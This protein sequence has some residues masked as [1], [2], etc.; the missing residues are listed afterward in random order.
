MPAGFSAVSGSPTEVRAAADAWGVRYARVDTDDPAA[1]L[2]SH[3]ADVFLVDAAGTLRARFPFGTDAPTMTAVIDALDPPAPTAGATPPGGSPAPGGS[4]RPAATPAPV[5][6][7]EPLLVSSSV[8]AGRASPVIFTLGSRSVAGREPASLAVQPADA[9][10][11]PAGPPVSA[12]TVRP[13][14]I[15]EVSYVA[16]VDIAAPGSWTLLVTAGDADGTRHTGSF[17]LTALDQGGSA[18]LGQPAPTLRTQVPADVGGNLTYL[19]TDPLPD[20]RLHATS[21]ADALAAGKPFVLVV[22]SWS[23][24]VTPQ[25]GQAIVMAKRLLDRWGEVAFIHHEP[26][27]YDVVTT[28]P[29]ITGSIQDPVLTEVATAWGVGSE[30]WGAFSMPWLFVVDGDGIIRAKYQGIMGSADVDVLLTYL[31]G[32]E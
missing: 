8:W 32:A 24:K 27:R 1:Y 7:L 12:S 3:T 18:A 31:V 17:A 21:T 28:E 19:T 25:C 13:S 22:D 16:F 14:G 11:A 2:M 10:G 26:Y 6:D 9:G 30:P 23:F 5:A 29:V 15:D 20:P 4:D